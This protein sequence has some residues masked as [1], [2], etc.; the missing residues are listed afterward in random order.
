MMSYDEAANWAKADPHI[1][2]FTFNLQAA[3]SPKPKKKVMVWF[4]S[5]GYNVNTNT[6]WAHYMKSAGTRNNRQH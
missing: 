4:K 6:N 5:K 3:G 1:A 2:A